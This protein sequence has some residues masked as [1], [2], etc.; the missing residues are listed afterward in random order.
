[1]NNEQYK[2]KILLVQGL[3]QSSLERHPS[4]MDQSQHEQKSMICKGDYLENTIMQKPDAPSEC[5]CIFQQTTKSVCTGIVSFYQVF[6]AQE[7]F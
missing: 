3:A 5:L 6:L 2:Y 7:A 1:M 4:P